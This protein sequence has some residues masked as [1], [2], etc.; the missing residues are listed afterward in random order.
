[1]FRGLLTSMTP[2]Q[3]DS[4]MNGQP[5]AWSPEQTM[6]MGELYMGF[7]KAEEARKANGNAGES[8]TESVRVQL[9]ATLPEPLV[10][11]VL[12]ALG[13]EG[14]PAALADLAAELEPQ[15]P[16]AAGALRARAEQIR[17]ATDAT[18]GGQQR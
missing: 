1:M 12:S 7:A 8:G 11:R 15:Y 10:A 13:N 6:L 14:A 16:L 18:P 5:F 2:A 17:N 3:L 4:L 9:D